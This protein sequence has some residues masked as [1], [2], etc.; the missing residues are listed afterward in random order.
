MPV[1]A[2]S[3]MIILKS[4][5]LTCRMHKTKKRYLL[6]KPWTDDEEG[7]TYFRLKD[8]EAFLRKNKFFEYKSH[9]VAQRLR[10]INGESTVFK[11]KGRAVGYGTYRL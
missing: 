6:R 3:S 9:K 4:S 11:I 7:L 5:V 1:S 2:V 8:F 10:D